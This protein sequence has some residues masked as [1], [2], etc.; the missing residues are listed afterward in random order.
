MLGGFHPHATTMPSDRLADEP[1]S[2]RVSV[3]MPSFEQAH[4]IGRALDSLMDQSLHDWEAIIVD[5]GSED[6]TAAAL[7]PWLR[8]PRLRVLR[9]GRNLGLGR[10]LN[11]G[12]DAAR[13]PLVAYLPSDDL[14]YREHLALLVD[15]IGREAGAVLV[16][17]G[18]RYRYNRTT[19]GVAPDGWL[20]LV[21]CLHRRVPLRWLERA[22][23]ESDDLG[24]LYW[25]RLAR[26]GRFAASGKLS[27]EWVDHPAQ[28]HKLM[29]EPVGSLNPFRSHYRIA[30]P[31]RFHASSGNPIDE[32][33]LYAG[34]QQDPPAP[35][36][37]AGCRLAIVLAGELAYNPDRVL[38]LRALGHKLYGLWTARPYRFNSVGPLPFAGVEELPR[39]GWRPALAALRPDLVYAQ[40]NWQAVPFAHE[41]MRACPD[42]P[43]VWHFKEGPFICLEKGSWP[44]LAELCRLADACIYSS[45]EMGDWF[46]GA[47]PG[48]DAARPSLVLDG[49]LPR[50][51]WF[52][53]ARAPLLSDLDGEVHTVVPGRP[54]G[55]HPPVV[56]ELAEHG[57]HLHFYGEFTQRQW[58]EWIGKAQ[59][60]APR[61]L[62][63]H[64]NVDQRRWVG[65]FSRYDAGWL[66]VFHS[67]NGGEIRRADWDDLNLPARMAT[68][69]MA[70]LPM[71]QRDSRGAIVAAQA[72]AARLG[73]G[74]F[75]D[76]IAGLARQLHDRAAMAALRDQVWRQRLEFCFERHLPALL[77]LFHQAIAHARTRP[78]APAWAQAS[79]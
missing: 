48:L 29:R 30:E 59:A 24:R 37:A 69:A 77:D 22:E 54:I 47:L 70:G 9:H 28:R 45:A 39:A 13:A 75:F 44:Q 4:F 74:L 16:H 20:Q 49:D 14:W 72:L 19:L 46:R 65:E 60:L 68:L 73:V 27:C 17:A 1:T 26:F 15:L 5:D 61:H 21:Q 7:A 53:A 3:L 10:A 64:G 41:V 63:L 67:A 57:I 18:M 79:R 32:P 66:H 33:G 12:L 50:A 51:A 36:P 25:Q 34:S 8:D 56:G 58:R 43:F 11:S 40:L 38:A 78:R 76:D 62:H 71:I 52:E 2:P 35:A 31:L 55:L 42:I 6:G 23:I